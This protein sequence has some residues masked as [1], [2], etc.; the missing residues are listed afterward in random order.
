MADDRLHEEV[1]F[2]AFCF[3][4][5]VGWVTATTLSHLTQHGVSDIA[6]VVAAIGGAAISKMFTRNDRTFGNYCIGLA[7][8]FFVCLLLYFAYT[9]ARSV[10]AP[11]PKPTPMPTQTP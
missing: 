4:A 8:G 2:G 5:V 11:T 9:D 7:A 6:A 1:T 10:S 3:G